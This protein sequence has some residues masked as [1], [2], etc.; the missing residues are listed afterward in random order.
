[1]PC[2]LAVRRTSAGTEYVGDCIGVF[3]YELYLG[4]MVEPVGGAFCIVEVMDADADNEILI[5]LCEDWILDDL[6]N[7]ETYKKK[8]YLQ[9][10]SSGDP[11][12]IELLTN[13]RVQVT[14]SQVVD[15]IRERE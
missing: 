10:V 5:D 2:K 12:F 4:N 7:H 9:P 11:F 8:K 3:P 6:N 15:Y 1:M 13:G 14:L